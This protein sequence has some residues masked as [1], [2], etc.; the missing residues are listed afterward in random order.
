MTIQRDMLQELEDAK[1]SLISA[2]RSVADFPAALE[3]YWLNQILLGQDY[4]PDTCAALI[5]SVSAADVLRV[6][7]SAE[8]DAIY[9]L[10]GE[11]HE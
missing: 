4:D 3:S 11:S 10:K 5:E 9:F 2:Y 8:C 1:R 7:N 6:A